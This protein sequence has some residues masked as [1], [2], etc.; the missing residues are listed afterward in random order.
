MSNESRMCQNCNFYQG[1]EG[2]Q[3]GICCI[4]PPQIVTVTNEVGV[5]TPQTEWPIVETGDWCGEFTMATVSS[6]C[7]GREPVG[8]P[9]TGSGGTATQN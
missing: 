5:G 2:P 9:V 6:G 8:C 7:T 3:D 1:R 4:K